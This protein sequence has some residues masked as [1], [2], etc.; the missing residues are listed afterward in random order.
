M[1]QW[2]GEPAIGG[3]LGVVYSIPLRRALVTGSDLP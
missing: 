2:A 1:A 3:N